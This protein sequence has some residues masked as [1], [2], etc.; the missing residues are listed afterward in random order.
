MNYVS[1]IL[2]YIS[3]T[4]DITEIYLV[5]KAPPLDRKNGKLIRIMDAVLTSEDVRDTLLALRSYTSP[6]LGPLGSEGTFSFGIHNVGRLRVSYIT[7]RGSY[8]VKIVKTPYEVPSLEKLCSDPKTVQHLDQLVRIHFCG[9]LLVFGAN[10]VRVSTFVYS[11]LQYVS[12]NYQKV[13]LILEKPLSFLLRHDK[14]V[15]IQREVGIDTPTFEEGLKDVAYINP[16]IVYVA[17]GEIL[18]DEDVFHIVKVAQL[19]TLVIFYSPYM[20]EEAVFKSFEKH[21]RIVKAVIKVEQAPEEKLHVII[22][23]TLS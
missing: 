20:N 8:V 23:N 5:P 10:P 6:T 11:A 22:T 2:S 19:N 1:Q 16:D 12:R 14:S 4:P 9:I 15:I 17:Y 3:G 13:I 21:K 18:P 7:Q